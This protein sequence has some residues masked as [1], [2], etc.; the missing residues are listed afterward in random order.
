MK[1]F[2]KIIGGIA[3]LMI[4]LLIFL[5]FYFT[6]ERLRTMILPQVQEAAGSEVE[7]DAMSITFF[8]TFPR[9]GLDMQGLRIPD[10]NGEPVASFKSVLLSV[11]LFPLLRNEVNISRLSLDKPEIFYTVYPDST[12]NIDFLLEE[13]DSEQSTI[14]LNIPQINIS[15]GSIFYNDLTTL[16]N[17]RMTGL[18]TELSLYYSDVIETDMDASLASLNVDIDGVNYISDLPLSLN[19][20]STL[21]L[22]NERLTF[23][24][25]IFSI[26]GLSLN[27]LGSVSSWSGNEPHLSLQIRSSSENFGELLRLAPPD[28]EE[29]LSNMN[30][31][32]SLQLE[33]SVEGVYNESVYPRIDLTIAVADGYLQNPDLPEAIEDINFEITFNNDLATIQNLNARAGNNSITGSG[34]IVNPLEDNATFSLDI[35]GDVNLNTINNFYS[36]SDLGIDELAGL[37]N[38]NAT[39]AGQL[40]IPEE[41]TFS[42]LFN[43][44][45]GRLKYADVPNTIEN[46]NFRL[47]ANQDR[48]Q[49]AESG[50][51]AADNQ[52]TLAGSILRPLDKDSRTVDVQSNVN[53]DLA[54]IK[55]FY[56]IDEDTLAMRGL[57]TANIVLRGT[58]DPDQIESL[59]Q[60][61]SFNLTDGYFYH[62][63]VNNPLE[64]IQF[65]AQASGRRLAISDARF[66]SGENQLIMSGT[67]EN[68]LSD[69]PLVD[70]TF[71][72]NALL[73]SISSYY[74]LEPWI[75]EL[76]GRAVMNLNTKG[77]INEIHRLALAG[78]FEVSGVSALGDSIPLP[79]TNLSGTMSATPNDMTLE[80]FSMNFGES[81]IN[82]Q[83]NLRNYMRFFEENTSASN[84]PAITGRYNSR[85]LNMDEMIDWEDESDDPFPIELPNLTADVD[86]AI[87]RMVILGLSITDMSGKGRITPSTIQI[88]DAQATLFDGTATGSMEWNVPDPLQTN[89]RFNGQLTGLTAE[90]F[91]RETGFLGEN[92][93]I[94][95]Y[96]NGEFNA[97][98]NYF[99]QLAPSLAPDITSAVSEGSFGM[100]KAS[101]RGHPIQVKIAE[102]LKISELESLVMDEWTANYTIQNSVMTLR[103]FK[104]TSGNLGFELNGTLNMVTDQINYNV[105][106]LLPERF[107]RGIATVLSGRAADALQLEDGRM[108]IPLR[109]TGTTASPQV[110]PNTEVIERVIEDRI[111]DGAGDVLR[112]LFGG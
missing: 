49:I 65:N 106:L 15:D 2:I 89:I 24:E 61:S 28:F 38:F 50:F 41:A 29:Q 105:T 94:H 69:D 36:I 4:A 109:I 31:R 98:L 48:I 34:E 13:S 1:T 97:E 67:V 40:N 87:D 64:N 71:D 63:I 88:N 103:D 8:R 11:E 60:Q 108:A 100:D 107:K 68:Y 54:T 81:D 102:Y 83:G 39:A 45:N 30:T 62:S 101:L 10:P 43:L 93:T 85:L 55:E 37:L 19:Q 104:L 78:T 111:R 70:L 20:I 112:R 5:N 3:V 75:Q 6:D 17:V 27:L 18:D 57:L 26:R 21:D 82:L 35:N 86:A 7:I 14:N 96:M 12:T 9:F 42:G 56:P 77:P 110:R 32:G 52:F 59:L 44:T 66:K 47:N 95:Q 91:F 99:T 51:T 73:S 58:P 92:S 76:T 74:T 53:F 23:T 22:E 90:T 46:I 80:Q 79:V 33:G 16:A 72:G 25:G 84:R